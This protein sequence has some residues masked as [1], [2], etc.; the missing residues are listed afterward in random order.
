[1][2][3]EKMMGNYKKKDKK[4]YLNNPVQ[5]ETNLKESKDHTNIIS[6]IYKKGEFA[7]KKSMNDLENEQKAILLSSKGVNEFLEKT[8]KAETKV[9]VE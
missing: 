9:A 7:A 4:K 6:N 3:I 8:L 5:K 1:M 2:K